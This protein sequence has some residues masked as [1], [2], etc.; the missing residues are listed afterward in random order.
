MQGIG[1][2]DRDS[3]NAVSLFLTWAEHLADTLPKPL[4]FGLFRY[5]DKGVFRNGGYHNLFLGFGRPVV[6]DSAVEFCQ[7]IEV[8]ELLRKFIADSTFAF[9]KAFYLA[10][11]Q[12]V[13]FADF[14]QQ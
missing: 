1:L 4:L 12:F 7:R 5:V 14:K 10:Y 6:V 9:Y 11:H 2:L 8:V 3:D 13:V